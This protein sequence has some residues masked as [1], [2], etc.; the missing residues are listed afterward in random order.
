M[1][2]DPQAG[3]HPVMFEFID[4]LKKL[5]DLTGAETLV[6]VRGSH[7]FVAWRSCAGDRECVKLLVIY[8]N[9]RNANDGGKYSEKIEQLRI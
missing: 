7:R 5:I 3:V 8:N 6:Q 9:L 2:T 4:A 1:L